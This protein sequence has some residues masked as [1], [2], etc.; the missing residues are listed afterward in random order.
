MAETFVQVA[1]DGSGKKI[2]NI[3]IQTLQADGT[4]ATTYMQVVNIYDEFG[5]A[6]NYVSQESWQTQML[7]ETRAIRIAMQTMWDAGTR[8]KERDNFLDLALEERDPHGRR[9]AHAG[10]RGRARDFEPPRANP[11]HRQRHR[12][13]RLPRLGRPRPAA[14][15]R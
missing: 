7:D 4:L 15:R 12:P 2:R 10:Q 6:V 1:A 5:N 13:G 11:V 8:P 3:S 9:R 14:R